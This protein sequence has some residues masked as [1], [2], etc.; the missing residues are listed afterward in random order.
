MDDARARAEEPGPV[1]QLDGRDAVLGA[2]L[3]QLARLL[4]GVDVA[5]E[6]VLE[7]IDRVARLVMESIGPEDSANPPPAETPPSS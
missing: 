5:D 6:A 4:V 1:Q 2:A 7:A 3:L